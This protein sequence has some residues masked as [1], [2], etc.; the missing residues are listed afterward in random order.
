MNL[1][2]ANLPGA[3]SPM[4]P[5]PSEWIAA[6]AHLIP[7]G[8]TVLDLACGRGRH[9]RWLAA[10]G[11][12]VL[13]VD[14]DPAALAESTGVAG[15]ET[16]CAELEGSAWPLA[17]RQFDGIVVTNYLHR[18]LWQP[19]LAALAP[20]GVLLYETFAAGN[21]EVGK[22]SNP[23]FLLR[24][25]ELLAAVG[26]LRVVAFQDV[27]REQPGPAFIQRICAVREPVSPAAASAYRYAVLQL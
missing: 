7:A 20:G 5:A 25:G 4:P 9:A 1:L 6:W 17:G 10:R 16:L 2:A 26:G 15:V 11:Y 22:P 13:G 21:A 12:R 18:P 27:F 14:R 8:G 24:P 23:D 19:L 3:T